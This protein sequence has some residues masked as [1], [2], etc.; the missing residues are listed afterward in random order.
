VRRD[1]AGDGV[2]LLHTIER[3]RATTAAGPHSDVT[4]FSPAAAQA[5]T[6][7]GINAPNAPAL[8]H[9]TEHTRVVTLRERD[10]R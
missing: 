1:A 4:L 5:M 3:Y 7:A 9:S 2:Q 10:M 6:L 8:W